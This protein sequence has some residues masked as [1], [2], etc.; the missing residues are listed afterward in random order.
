MSHLSFC[1]CLLYILDRTLQK[2]S[3]ANCQQTLKTA[4]KIS[5]PPHQDVRKRWPINR[6]HFW[7]SYIQTLTENPPS[8]PM[9]PVGMSKEVIFHLTPPPC[10]NKQWCTLSSIG[11]YESFYAGTW[12]STP[13]QHEDWKMC[14]K[15]GLVNIPGVSRCRRELN[16]YAYPVATRLNEEVQC[17]AT[18]LFPTMV[19]EGHGGKLSLHLYQV[20][21][22][23]KMVVGHRI[24]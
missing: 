2:P 12:T 17:L 4:H 24:S 9:V 22:R 7:P 18:P 13:T 5:I 3:T 14:C 19:S 20:S 6:R 23:Q 16:T 15:S 11:W 8:V 1:N 10:E 21:M